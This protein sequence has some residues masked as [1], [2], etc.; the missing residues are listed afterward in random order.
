MARPEETEGRQGALMED[1]GAFRLRPQSP[2]VFASSLHDLAFGEGNQQRVAFRRAFAELSKDA[3]D[4]PGPLEGIS[5]ALLS[6]AAKAAL[7]AGLVDDLEWLAPEAAG[8]ALFTLASGL[9]IG[10]EQR[11]LGRRALSR[12]LVGTAS[13]FAA[14]ATV[15]ARVGAKAFGSPP[16]V[17]RTALL[18]ELPLSA[19]ISDGPLALTLASRKQLARDWLLTPSTRSLA[20]RRFGA[21]ILE[22]A[23][24]ELVRKNDLSTRRFFTEGGPLRTA[25]FRLLEDRESLVWRHAAVAR[26]L[27]ASQSPDHIDEL[28]KDLDPSLS[29]TEWRRAATSV[30]AMAGANAERAAELAAKLFSSDVPKRDPGVA[31]AFAWGLARAAATEPDAALLLFHHAVAGP[32]DDVAESALYLR[33]ELGPCDFVERARSM[34]LDRLSRA[35]HARPS[36]DGSVAQRRELLRA[37]DATPREDEPLRDQITRALELFVTTGAKASH[38]RGL[39]ALASAHTTVDALEALSAGSDSPM[40][41]RTSFSVLRDVDVS[42][43]ERDVLVDLLRLDTNVDKIRAHEEAL[44]GLRSR[45]AEF[46]LSDRESADGS[47]TAD[48]PHLVLHFAR[49][50]ALLHLVDSDAGGWVPNAADR[51][52]E[53]ARAAERTRWL[54]TSKAVLARIESRPSR[55]LRRALLAT[56]ARCLDGL[57]RTQACDVVDALLVVSVRASD[58]RDFEA[59]GEASMDPDLRLAFAAYAAFLS[60]EDDGE[61]PSTG[62]VSPGLVDRSKIDALETLAETIAMV[63]S[64]RSDTLRSVLARVGQSLA[65]LARARSLKS[66]ASANGEVEP[67]LRLEASVLSL[68]QMCVGARARVFEPTDTGLERPSAG[69][70][71][72]TAITRVISRSDDEID[73]DGLALGATQLSSG[74]P[75]AIAA[76]VRAVVARL[77]ELP[78]DG[79]ILP[80]APSVEEPLPEWVPARRVLGAFYVLRPLGSGAAGSVY[81]VCRAEDKRDPNAERFALKVPDYSANAARHLSETEFFNLFRA[82]ASAL[83]ALPPHANL[84]QLVTFDLSSRPRPILVMELVEGPSLERTIEAGTMDLPKCFKV[85]DEVLAGLEVMHEANVGHLDVKPANVVLRHGETAVLVDFGLAGRNIRPGCV[86]G[87]YGAPEVWGATPEGAKPRPMPADIYAFGC[88]AFELV[89]GR[90][91][92]AE[93]SEVAMISAHITHDGLPPRLRELSQNPKLQPFV[94][95]LF[96]TLRRDPASRLKAPEVRGALRGVAKALEGAAWPIEVKPPPV[97]SRTPG[98]TG[99]VR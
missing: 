74:I 32:A 55:A 35:E 60:A 33:R 87:P 92:F 68:Q 29:P 96:A 50:R 85:L 49:L 8:R 3:Y 53:N 99:A 48:P 24:A 9:P 4:G 26:G 45:V 73:P 52:D 78:T 64:A 25:F 16:V 91:L 51:A 40:A 44:G 14:I 27:L 22:R 61:R 83:V 23:A 39:E 95:L 1:T 70:A 18:V 71:L 38:A 81:V 46:I 42:L 6:V 47:G 93:G 13:T 80:A 62:S 10:A 63:G 36:D 57:V 84:A 58:A 31:A 59:L 7:S 17:A 66:V 82:E 69:R 2:D 19:D 88:L 89:T 37:L 67:V 15:M 86:S 43:L 41:R 79:S 28:E 34:A 90:Q 21:R 30:A 65:T 11:E 20:A 54:S 72:S 77:G 97:R 94:E 12:L 56:L 98:P 76:L 75:R 5:P